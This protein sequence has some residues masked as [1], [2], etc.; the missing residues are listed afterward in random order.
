MLIY[1]MFSKGPGML[2][3]LMRKPEYSQEL[4]TDLQKDIEL[5]SQEQIEQIVILLYTG[6]NVFIQ[7]IRSVIQFKKPLLCLAYTT[8][9][10]GISAVATL[11]GDKLLLWICVFLSFILPGV[12]VKKTK[13]VYEGEKDDNT[14]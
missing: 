4:R 11:L 5:L 1:F 6:V 12:V 7:L 14:S 13:A 10:L 3:C 2:M 8:G 9:F